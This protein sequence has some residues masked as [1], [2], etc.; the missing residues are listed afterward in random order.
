MFLL[1]KYTKKGEFEHLGH[2]VAYKVKLKNIS[3]QKSF[4]IPA[5][6]FAAFRH[7]IC[8][9]QWNLKQNTI[10]TNFNKI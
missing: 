2:V 10:F 5:K 4:R 7:N 9:T 3:N 8:N 6:N 1:E